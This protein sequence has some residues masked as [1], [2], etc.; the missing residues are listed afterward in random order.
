M[1]APSALVSIVLRLRIDRREFAA[2]RKVVPG[3]TSE[4][5]I[6]WNVRYEVQRI[7]WKSACTRLAVGSLITKKQMPGSPSR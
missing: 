6:A 3:R 2:K 5:R 1:G 7:L 4:I